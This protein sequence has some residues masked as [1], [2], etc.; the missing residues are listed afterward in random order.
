MLNFNR[1]I[2]TVRYI[3]KVHLC[4]GETIWRNENDKRLIKTMP[5]GLKIFK[6]TKENLRE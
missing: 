3:T 5:R 1:K 6:R 4:K 2:C